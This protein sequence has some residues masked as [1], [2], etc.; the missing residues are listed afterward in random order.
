M[1]G[2]LNRCVEMQYNIEHTKRKIR[3]FKAVSF[4]FLPTYNRCVGGVAREGSHSRLVDFKCI[5]NSV[6]IKS[7]Y[8]YCLIDI[9]EIGICESFCILTVFWLICLLWE[10]KTSWEKNVRS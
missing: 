10:G 1:Q 4:V 8:K 3:L 7:K 6:S 9:C 2:V 5:Y